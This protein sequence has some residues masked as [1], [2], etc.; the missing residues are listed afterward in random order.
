MAVRTISPQQ[1]FERQQQGVPLIDVREAA[2]WAE[3]MAEC[4]VPVSRSDLES[5]PC[6]HLSGFGQHVMLICAGGKRSDACAEALAGQ[7]YSNLL[8]VSGGT[9]AWRAAG[10]PMRDYAVSDFEQRYARQMILPNIGRAGQDKLA[11][12]RVLVIG[13]GGLGSPSA[14]YLAAAGVGHLTLIDD[15]TVA[16]SNLQRQILHKNDN[17]GELKVNSAK[18]TL[19]A[20][21]P[22]IAVEIHD[23]KISKSNIR[24][25]L[26]N[27]DLV[28]DGTD[29]FQA[30]YAISD[31]CTEVGMPWVYGAVYRFEG[32]VS[33]F[34]ASKPDQRGLCYRCLFPE[35]DTQAGAPNCTEAGVL[36]VAPGLIGIMQASEALKYLLG[37]GEVLQGRLLHVDLLGMRFHETR[38]TADPECMACGSFTAGP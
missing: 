23:D 1:A 8:S 15:D 26:K 24:N 28:I 29:N 32:Q 11:K 7:G 34:H 35:G 14:F 27:I 18:S 4:A 5:N 22:S 13:A 12:A 33:V 25:Y 6:A 20:L 16:L 2:E 37:I 3:G 21:N 31:A 17:I 30:R 38:M 19:N 10:L 36:G 9:Q